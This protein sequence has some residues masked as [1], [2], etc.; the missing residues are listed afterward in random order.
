MT[1]IFM[2]YADAKGHIKLI[3]AVEVL[4]ACIWN[5]CIDVISCRI[6]IAYIAI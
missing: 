4:Q 1:K 5:Q 2:L 6:L 3:R